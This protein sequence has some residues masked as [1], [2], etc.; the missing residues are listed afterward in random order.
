MATRLVSSS[1]V[2]APGGVHNSLEDLMDVIY[3]DVDCLFHKGL[4]LKYREKQTNKN[5]QNRNVES[6]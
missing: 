6:L 4:Q 1:G 5:K 3:L 2:S